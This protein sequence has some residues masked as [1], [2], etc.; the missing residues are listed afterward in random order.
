M[1]VA[2]GLGDPLCSLHGHEDS[3]SRQPIVSIQTKRGGWGTTTPAAAPSHVVPWP[4]QGTG[5]REGVPPAMHHF[6][7]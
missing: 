3:V 1:A 5:H 4:A 2:A 7:A 6:V